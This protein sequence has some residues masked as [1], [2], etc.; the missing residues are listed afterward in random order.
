ML[1]TRINTLETE[2]AADVL[3]FA[4]PIIWSMDDLIRDA[5]EERQ[6]KRGKLAVVLETGGG[7]IEVAQRIADTIRKHYGYVEFIIPNFAMSA[8]T[9]LC[10][11]GDAIHMDYY[12]ILGPIDPQVERPGSGEWVPALGYLKQYERLIKKSQEG[13]L[14][15]AELAF[16]VQRFDPGELY[17]YEQE[18]E[19]SISLLKEWLVKYKFKNW[20]KTETRGVA[21]TE[22]IKIDRA[23]AIAEM[24]NETERWH[25][26]SRPISME[27]LR[28]DLKLQIED[29]GLNP[30]LN[31]AI[32]DYYKLLRDYMTKTRANIAVHWHEHFVSLGGD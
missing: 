20:K 21:V 17:R 10:M 7:Y 29:F 30:T 4:G 8:G 31:R 14:T 26:H 16:L 28:K 12:S 25:S 18:R 22:Q 9:V 24:L 6:P 27:V 15:T 1:D 2:I 11:A 19:L 32:R 23:A 13:E 3:A 5:V